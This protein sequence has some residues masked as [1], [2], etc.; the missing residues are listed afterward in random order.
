MRR[1]VHVIH[2]IAAF[3]IL[4]VFWVF[5]SGYLDPFHLV[6][7]ILSAALITVL[8]QDLLIPAGGR[9]QMKKI[10]RFLLYIPWLLFEIFQAGLD[11][12]YRVLHPSMPIDPSMLT[13]EVPFDEDVPQTVFANSITLTPGTITVDVTD[14][15]F[16]VHALAEDFAQDLLE[17][18]V[19]EKRVE[20]IFKEGT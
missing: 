15:T 19:M 12:A 6:G 13:F 7:G 20:E 10:G 8:S 11:V 3:S 9:N 18:K 2:K 5:L 16:V 4:L 14:S 17:R 1:K